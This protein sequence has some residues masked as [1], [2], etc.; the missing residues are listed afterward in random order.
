MNQQHLRTATQRA[1]GDVHTVDDLHSCQPTGYCVNATAVLADAP[2]FWL[3][4]TG[5]NHKFVWSFLFAATD[6]LALFRFEMKNAQFEKPPSKPIDERFL[7]AWARSPTV[8]HQ[9]V[10]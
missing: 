10:S 8:I 2:Q 1:I 4:T 3:A 6:Q 7:F 5:E 9:A